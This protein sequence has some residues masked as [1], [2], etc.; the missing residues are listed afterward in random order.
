MYIVG[1]MAYWN[2]TKSRE[3]CAFWCFVSLLE[4]WEG[5]VCARHEH[6]V[7]LAPVCFDSCLLATPLLDFFISEKY[8][9]RNYS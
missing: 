1:E 5:S 4:V 9:F 7:N 2:C 8:E 3:I 6:E